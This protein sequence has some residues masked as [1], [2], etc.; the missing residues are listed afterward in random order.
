[1]GGQQHQPPC[2]MMVAAL[3]IQIIDPRHPTASPIIADTM[4]HR[5]A[6]Q[7]CP[8]SQ[9]LA[10]VGIARSSLGFRR[11]ARSAPTTIDARWPSMAGHRIDG[12]R[13]GKG[14]HPQLPCAAGQDLRV[15]VHSMG[16]HRELVSF[17]GEWTALPGHPQFILDP[18]VMPS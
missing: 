12:D 15:P 17:R 4:D 10:Q 11:A 3:P 18:R 2:Q 1:M 6:D 8:S 16:W 7:A 5:F 13:W 14:M 9:R